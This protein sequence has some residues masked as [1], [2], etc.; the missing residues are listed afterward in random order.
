MTQAWRDKQELI[1][2]LTMNF[3]DNVGRMTYSRPTRGDI[4][5]STS[6]RRW[7]TASKTF[8][9]QRLMVRTSDEYDK[10]GMDLAEKLSPFLRHRSPSS[11]GKLATILADFIREI[12]C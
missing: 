11:M 1:T 2:E 12:K 5:F 3:A 4:Y 9:D 8:R 6:Y 10:L 7:K